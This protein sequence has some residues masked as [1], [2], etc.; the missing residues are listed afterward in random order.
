MTVSNAYSR[1]DQLSSTLRETI[2]AAAKNLGYA[3]P[4]PKARALTR[5]ST[6]AIGV[7]LA[8]SMRWAFIDVVAAEFLGAVA[9]ELELTGQALTLLGGAE[10]ATARNVAVDG[11]LILSAHAPAAGPLIERR[12]PA[13]YVDEAAPEGCSSITVDDVGGAR[14][15]SQHLID[16]GHRRLAIVNP[17]PGV[18]AQIRPNATDLPETTKFV[19]SQRMAGWLAPLRRVG[20][21]P[22]V[23]IAG[24]RDYDIIHEL[25]S[26]PD[27]PTGLVCFSDATAGMALS[28]AHDLGLDVPAELSIVGF[29][30]AETAR[31]MRPALTTVRQDVTT[32]G[33]A[34]A[35]ELRRALEAFRGH[36]AFEPK[37]TVLPTELIV[38][39]STAPPATG[40][41]SG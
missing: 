13:V 15:A 5:G 24:P 10:D 4:D 26:L 14:S 41:T 36:I 39:G 35:V 19:G 22:R 29:D 1:P 2:L 16:L 6:G 25:L 30:D 9:A 32:K 33:T 34:A 38:R 8:G 3:G 21:E 17:V 37:H 20:I 28:V 31:T 23:A 11:A 12:I 7:V 40:R 18:A 27:R